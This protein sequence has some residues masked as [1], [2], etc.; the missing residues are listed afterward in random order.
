MP[1]VH[2][3]IYLLSSMGSLRATVIHIQQPVF[4]VRIRI[5][6]NNTSLKRPTSIL[7]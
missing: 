6:T 7:V 3:K 2:L 4:N 1:F 5:Y